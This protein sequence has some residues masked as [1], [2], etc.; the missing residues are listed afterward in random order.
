[1]T[2]DLTHALADLDELEGL[3]RARPAWSSEWESACG[4][5]A[6]KCR[7]LGVDVELDRAG[8]QWFATRADADATLAVGGYLD[9]GGGTDGSLSIL[10]GLELMRRRAAGSKLVP[11]KL[12]N[13]ADGSGAR[14]GRPFG[15]SAAAGTLRD[16]FVATELLDDQGS[17]LLETVQNRGIEPRMAHMARRLL[18]PVERYV[19][20]DAVSGQEGARAPNGAEGIERCRLTWRSASEGSDPVGGANRFS[21]ELAERVSAGGLPGSAEVH[22]LDGLSD[23][24]GGIVQQLDAAANDQAALEA[25]L[26]LALDVSDRI[27]EG[28]GLTVE[29]QR[30][31]RTSP[32]PFD[33]AL[34]E[35][36]RSA[37]DDDSVA[38]SATAFQT[39]AAEVARGGT[40]SALVL[41]PGPE[42]SSDAERS[43]ATAL[44][45]LETFAR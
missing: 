28:R 41:L 40:P 2:T 34:T 3:A 24:T 42:S 20:L 43:L 36:V 31:W 27:G 22:E 18:L 8:N 6:E 25:L 33:A 30:V 16:W 45:V 9:T 14:F 35:L 7:S 23:R 5:L 13:W 11:F 1:M 37:L 10:A 19:E 26:G 29:W 12:V 17:S 44:R 39:P 32:V 15:P 38:P 21:G 4:W